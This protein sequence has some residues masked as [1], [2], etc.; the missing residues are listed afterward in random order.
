MVLVLEFLKACA[1][2]ICWVIHYIFN[3]SLR[4]RKGT[5]LWKTSCVVPVPKKTNP[6]EFSQ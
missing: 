6:T 4:L 1:D 3:L 2:Q 5:C